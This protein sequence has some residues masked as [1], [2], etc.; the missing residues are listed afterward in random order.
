MKLH[1]SIRGP[2]ASPVSLH[3]DGSASSLRA[4][5]ST[6][7]HLHPPASRRALSLTCSSQQQELGPLQGQGS[8]CLPD[9]PVTRRE[10]VGRHPTRNKGA[11]GGRLV[12][13]PGSTE[14]SLYFKSVYDCL[15]C[16]ETQP[17]FL[18]KNDAFY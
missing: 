15:V 14:L 10:P 6:G 17:S 4:R 13:L 7:S 18:R 2:P 9:K 5:G 1:D 8:G 11:A 12:G 16:S 3:Q